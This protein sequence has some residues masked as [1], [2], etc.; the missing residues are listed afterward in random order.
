MGISKQESSRNANILKRMGGALPVP[1]AL[2]K[3]LPNPS[4]VQSRNQAILGVCPDSSRVRR[5][6]PCVGRLFP[7]TFLTSRSHPMQ[8]AGQS[9]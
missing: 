5:R 2:P 6:C 9:P 8:V 7:A 1:R 4:P 3:P